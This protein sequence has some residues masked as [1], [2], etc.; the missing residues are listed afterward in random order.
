MLSI[1]VGHLCKGLANK[2]DVLLC[3]K[4]HQVQHIRNININDID[5]MRICY[6]IREVGW[7]GIKCRVYSTVVFFYTEFREYPTIS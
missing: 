2:V 7:R 5:R 1:A 4:S 6:E 3:D